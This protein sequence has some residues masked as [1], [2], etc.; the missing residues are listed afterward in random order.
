MERQ[1]KYAVSF[2]ESLRNSLDGRETFALELYEK[3]SPYIVTHCST[4]VLTNMMSRYAD[5]DI[6]E[7]VSPEGEN[8]LGDTYYEFYVDEGKLDE[9]ILRLF[10]AEK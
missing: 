7:I 1:K 6:V 10:Y 4:T 8:K 9:L 2:M 3:V 5:Y